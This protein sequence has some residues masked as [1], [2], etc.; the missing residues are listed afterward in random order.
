[1][2]LLYRAMWQAD[3]DGL[4]DI[5]DDQFRSWA[6]GKHQSLELPDEGDSP[7]GD[8][9]VRIVRHSNEYGSI[10]R[11]VLHEDDEESRW[12]TTLTAIH[13]SSTVEGWLWID[14]ENVRTEY[15]APAEIAAPRLARNLL[16]ALPSSHRG[17]LQLAVKGLPLGLPELDQF[18]LHL[19]DPRRDLPL[20]VFSTSRNTSPQVTNDRVNKAAK[21]LAGLGQVYLLLPRAQA[22]FTERLGTEMSVWS[23]ACRVYLPGV[24]LEDLEPHR[25][26]YFLARRLGWQS[27]DAGLL[28]ARHLSPL[29]ARQRAPEVY[30]KLRGL[31]DYDFQAQRDE[32]LDELER[33]MSDNSDLVAKVQSTTESYELAAME[34]EDLDELLV[35]SQQNLVDVWTAIDSA[36]VRRE[37][38]E[39]MG[40]RMKQSEEL[41][42]DPPDACGELAPLA[43]LYLDRVTFPDEAC[44]DIERLDQHLE[45]RKWARTSWRALQALNAYA[46]DSDTFSGGFHAWCA[47]GRPF[48]W[49]KDKMAMSESETVK[50]RPEFR[51]RRMLPIDPLALPEAERTEGT[52][53]MEAHIK[54]AEGGGPLAPRI[55]FY[56]DT[57]GATG[58]I[59]I[60][61]FGPHDYMINTRSN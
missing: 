8:V 37:V 57:D 5:A 34:A 24:N 28:L 53:F 26:R 38:E 33:E 29:V 4:L 17:P 60:G 30:V 51:Q 13:E 10:R 46:K 2:S 16:A 19:V 21:A 3:S 31:L 45:G 48:S 42:P 18:M 58:N 54:V 50:N 22:A 56:D 39:Q 36:G 1:M 12:I 20:V 49:N 41:V 43:Q 14:V 35:R 6:R 44:V 55:Y 9:D 7:P 23:G 25:H 15:F 11:W 32:L 61:F 27:L 40:L 47:S 59:H 52:I